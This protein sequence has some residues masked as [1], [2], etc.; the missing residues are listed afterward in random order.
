MSREMIG[1]MFEKIEKDMELKKK[2]TEMLLAY[3]KETE[4]VMA[5]KLVE[6]GKTS[7]YSFTN[8]ELKTFTNELLDKAGLNKEL[9]PED[10]EK[11]AGGTY[12]VVGLGPASAAVTAYLAQAQAQTILFAN[13]VNQQAQYATIAAATLAEELKQLS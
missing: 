13:M 2:Y 7:G 12:Q 1:K 9:S 11:V 3:Y 5:D 4:K 10:L 6:F 8:E